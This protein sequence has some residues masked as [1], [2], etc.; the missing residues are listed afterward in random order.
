MGKARR[1]PSVG[2]TPVRAET[3][4][5]PASPADAAPL[6]RRPALPPAVSALQ[7]QLRR[8]QAD[9]RA[10]RAA[11]LGDV[12]QPWFQANVARPGKQLEHVAEIWMELLPPRLLLHTK[13][14]SLTRCVLCVAVPNSTMRSELDMLLRQGLQRQIEERTRGAVF[15]VK[16]VTDAAACQ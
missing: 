14:L 9:D 5:T 10:P 1:S 15:R 8:K 3:R 12:L 4:K 6:A 11:S 7:K 2:K 16:T 13:L